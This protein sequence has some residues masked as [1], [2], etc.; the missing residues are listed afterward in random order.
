V[1]IGAEKS[2]DE[3]YIIIT[4]EKEWQGKVVFDSQRHKTILNLPIDYPRI[5]QFPEWFT[6]KEGEDYSIVSSN[7]LVSGKYSHQQLLS[8]ISLKLAAGEQLIVAIN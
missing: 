2:G 1:I 6:A 4:A 3:T 8:G 5:N 7:K